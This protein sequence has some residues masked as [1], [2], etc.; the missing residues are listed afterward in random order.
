MDVHPL[1][2]VHNQLNVS[3]VVVVRTA[4][5]LFVKSALGTHASGEVLPVS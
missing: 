4:R 1:S 2:Y 5:D 3:V